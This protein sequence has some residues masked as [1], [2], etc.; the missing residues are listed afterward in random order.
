MPE[1]LMRSFKLFAV[2]LVIFAAFATP[3]SQAATPAVF[4]VG[5]SV[6]DITP[7]TPQYLG[8]FGYGPKV[9]PNLPITPGVP[10]GVHDP[11]E[12]RSIAISNGTTL[13]AMTSVDTQGWFAGYAEGPYGVTDARN[14]AAAALKAIPSLSGLSIDAGNLI[15]SS[16]HSHAAPTIMGI[17]GSTDV[18]YLKTVH[19]QAVAA[20]VDAASHMH[21]A[22]LYASNADISGIIGSA[23]SETDV[24]QGW[25]PDGNTPVLWAKDPVTQAT[26]GMYINVPVH[27]DIVIGVDSFMSADHPGVE[28]AML[29]Q[30]LGGTTV[31]A[32]GTLG[33]QESFVQTDG[34]R[35]AAQVGSYVVTQVL[36]S[37]E[38]ATPIT[39]QTLA[40][41]T[42]YFA[43]PLTNPALAAFDAVGNTGRGGPGDSIASTCD[44]PGAGVCPIDRSLLPPYAIGAN[45]G[46]WATAIRIGDLVYATEPGEAFPEVSTM[47][48]KTINA[49]DVRVVGMA[50]DQLGYYYPPEA[51]P[52]TTVPNNSDHLFYNSSLLLADGNVTA[53]ALNAIALGFTPLPHHESPE[54]TPADSLHEGVQFIGVGETQPVDSTLTFIAATTGSS[55]G[56]FPYHNTA[57]GLTGANLHS[58]AGPFTD[59]VLGSDEASKTINWNFVEDSETGGK[60]VTHSFANP[61]RYLV[62]ASIPSTSNGTASFQ[63]WITITPPLTASVTLTGGELQAGLSGGTGHLVAAHWSF[64]DGGSQD[65]LYAASFE[66]GTLVVVDSA[67]TVAATSF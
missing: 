31:V 3:M 44:I 12:V 64:T 8:G 54:Y 36:R 43:V 61:G 42:Q 67:G 10:G 38:R 60:E 6:K 53:H 29:D 35:A 37:L 55:W 2:T 15:I 11:L 46:T 41:S 34:A 4:Q 23:V 59:P 21:T 25:A 19:D 9:D 32:M 52:F 13:V 33:R 7:T 22:N 65:G 40:A 1:E 5:F 20:I 45:I 62:T 47:I 57:I 39:D 18:S 28:R 26:L 17:W 27:A 48:R 50:Q 56:R 51:A 66:H 24:N 58:Q 30:K 63:Q 16:T 14:D 49:S